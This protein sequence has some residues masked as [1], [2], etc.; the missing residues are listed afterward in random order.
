MSSEKIN[1]NKYVMLNMLNA[2]YAEIFI[3][4]EK[5]DAILLHC[6]KSQEI[7]LSL[8]ITQIISMVQRGNYRKLFGMLDHKRTVS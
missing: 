8:L 4:I 3:R 7:Q 5:K 1:L 2:K 6:D